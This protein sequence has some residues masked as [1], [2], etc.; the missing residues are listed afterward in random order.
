MRIFR[1]RVRCKEAG[2]VVS[3]KR[4][5][6]TR[7]AVQGPEKVSYY[8]VTKPTVKVGKRVRKNKSLGKI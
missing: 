6:R 8:F 3:I 1:R 4:G 7:I 5:D 2:R